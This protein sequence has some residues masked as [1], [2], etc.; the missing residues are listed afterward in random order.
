MQR[1]TGQSDHLAGVPGTGPRQSSGRRSFASRHWCR[2]TP[3]RSRGMEPTANNYYFVVSDFESASAGWNICRYIREAKIRGAEAVVD[4]L[5]FPGK[6][7]IV[8]D[9][10]SMTSAAG[11]A[12]NPTRLLN[13]G[14]NSEVHHTN[15]FRNPSTLDFIASSFGI[16]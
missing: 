16:Q 15:Y 11:I 4:M 8:V 13:F 10:E 9:T 2:A 12:I 6:N 14:T 7:D 1:A 3:R 5:V